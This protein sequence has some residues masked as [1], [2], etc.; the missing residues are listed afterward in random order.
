MIVNTTEQS[1]CNTLLALLNR[2]ETCS[3]L[4]EIKVPLMI[5][6]GD[7]DKITPIS[8]AEMMHNDIKDSSLK[9]I[10]HAGHLS[11]LE[12]PE[13]F[14]KELIIFFDTI[15]NKEVNSKSSGGGSILTDLRN[16]VMTFLSFKAL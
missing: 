2:K 3:G 8:V 6:V 10:A 9:V 11:C 15:K 1:L 13:A 16:K 5:L 14:N 7:Q 12:N 4:S